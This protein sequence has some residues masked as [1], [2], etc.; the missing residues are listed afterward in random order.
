[1]RDELDDTKIAL[2][3]KAALEFNAAVITQ[4]GFIY[5]A[6]VK[7]SYRQSVAKTLNRLF[8]DYSEKIDNI[9]KCGKL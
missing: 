9:S 8:V 7:L 2:I 5:G 1:M 6:D 3:I 4:V